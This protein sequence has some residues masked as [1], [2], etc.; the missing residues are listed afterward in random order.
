MMRS[1]ELAHTME[2]LMDQLRDQVQDVQRHGFGRVEIIIKDGKI[3]TL[4][5]QKSWARRSYNGHLNNH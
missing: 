3:T 4:H 5:A 1:S 2:E